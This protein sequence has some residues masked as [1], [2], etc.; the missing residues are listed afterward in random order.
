MGR[1]R[2]ESPLEETPMD[3]TV[4]ATEIGRDADT[5]W[6]ARLYAAAQAINGAVPPICFSVGSLSG[7]YLLGPDKSLATMP[8][9]GY[10]VGV[11]MGAIPAALLMRRIGRRLGFAVGSLVAIMAG[12]LCAIA[13]MRA[14]F[15]GF[16]AAMTL[17]GMSGAFIQQYRFAAADSGGPE[18]RARAISWTLAGGIVAA[19]IGPQTVIY[20][21]DLFNP[22]P[23]AGSFLAM[24]GLACIGLVILLFLR[25]DARRPAPVEFGGSRGRPLSEFLRQ[26]RF[27]VAV[28][29]GMASY[30]LMSLTMTAAP[31]AIVSCGLGETNAALGIQWHVLAMFGPSFFT[32]R[33]INRYGKEKVIVLG[34]VLLGAGAVVA[35][36]GIDLFNFW[37]AMVLLGVGW[38][39]GFIGATAMLT[40][41][42]RPEEKSRI[43]GFNDFCVFA[44]V[45]VASFSSGQLLTT[46]GWDWMNYGSFP[47]IALCLVSLAWLALHG[48]R[49]TV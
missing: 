45:A 28:L 11:A 16:S 20:T 47:I 36:A 41:V 31:L 46:V 5:R 7:Y 2:E 22:I 44:A 12:I 32:G 35:L 27:L 43:Q 1:R 30:A 19:V 13:I 4:A 14:S 3:Q 6:N 24:S 8:V 18:A 17:A 33:L 21:H 10:T 9:T 37:G 29:C 15:L 23:F 48:R 49:R 42:Y 40:E 38:N 34:M 39:F 25:G 26:P